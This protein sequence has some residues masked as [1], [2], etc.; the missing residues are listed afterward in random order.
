VREGGRVIVTG[1]EVNWTELQASDP[2]N[3]T[4]TVDYNS[5]NLNIRSM[6]DA[7]YGAPTPKGTV[8]FV[9]ASTARIGSTSISLP[10]LETGTWPSQSFT[11]TR[12]TSNG[13]LTGIADTS[14]FE[15][16]Q[17]V[18]GPG[19]PN[20]ARVL[21]IVLNT[22]VTIDKTPTIAGSASLTLWT[23][24]VNV[25]NDGQVIGKGG[26]GGL[27]KGGDDNTGGAGEAG[28]LGFKIS[29][30]INLSGAGK[31][32]GGGGGGPGG[33]GDYAG[34]LGPQINGGG[35]G[36]GAGD[37]PGNGGAKGSGAQSGQPGTLDAGG[38]GGDSNNPGR[39][40]GGDGGDPGQ[41]GSG[42]TGPFLG[43]AGAAGKSV[44]GLALLKDTAFTGAYRGPQV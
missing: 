43:A 4:I 36:G 29:A 26:N 37:V 7:L 12:S 10:A 28:G 17:A 18:T 6:H 34:W 19:I 27:G 8:N 41:A 14:A 23:T 44:D 1:E 5:Y 2:L 9:V 40:D 25:I 31:I 22:S 32:D 35:G 33:G 39:Q 42:G 13:I 30:P 38:D 15:V 16:G 24:I 3:R 20:D 21:S 11:A